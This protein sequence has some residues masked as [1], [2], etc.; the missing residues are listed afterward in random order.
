[1]ILREICCLAAFTKNSKALVGRKVNLRWVERMENI[2]EAGG[3][4]KVRV[5]VGVEVFR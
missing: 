2:P 3:R 4:I 1:M 5:A